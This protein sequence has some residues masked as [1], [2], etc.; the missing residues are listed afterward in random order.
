MST[1]PAVTGKKL[2]QALLRNGYSVSRIVG[3]HHFVRHPRGR[4]TVIPVHSSRNVP[5]GTLRKILKDLQ[6][7]PQ[8]LRR[9]L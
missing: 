8:G 2:L 3:S 7:S 9:I 4:T 1:I 5:L 6:M